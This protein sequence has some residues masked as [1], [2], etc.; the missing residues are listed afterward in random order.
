MFINRCTVE[1]Y[2]NF[3]LII[4]KRYLRGN[5]VLI[6]M[7][8][9]KYPDHYLDNKTGLEWYLDSIGPL[10]WFDAM[11]WH[12]SDTKWRVPTVEELLTL[13]DYELTNPATAIPDMKASIYW[14]STPNPYFMRN[15]WSVYFYNGYDSNS[16]K[17]YSYYIRAVRGKME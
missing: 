1:F 12:S 3:L 2:V 11:R 14:S 6:N 13:V 8:F 17:G 10:T 4:N 16:Y 5:G 15:A 7:R 9:I